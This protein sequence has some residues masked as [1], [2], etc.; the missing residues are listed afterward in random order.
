M[1]AP[2]ERG[3]SGARESSI[4]H[5]IRLALGLVDGLVLWRNNSGVAMQAD[6]PVRYGL[7]LGGADLV[8]CY[9][10]HFVALEVKRPGGQPTAEQVA[11]LEV[12]RRNGGVAEVVHSV[13]EAMSV[14]EGMGDQA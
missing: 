5:D 12:V 7:G 2:E 3:V 4:L 14:V 8:G 1:L 13:E 9:R 6:R 10:G 11:W